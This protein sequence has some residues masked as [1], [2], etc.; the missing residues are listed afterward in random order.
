[1][2]TL[3]QPIGLPV[4]IRMSDV[5]DFLFEAYGQQR[6]DAI[7]NSADNG[8]MGPYSGLSRSRVETGTGTR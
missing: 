4:P 8:E 3:A 1:M 7:S 5:A 6:K 2:C